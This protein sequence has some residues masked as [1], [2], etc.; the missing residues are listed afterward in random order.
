MFKIGLRKCVAALLEL[1]Q[2]VLYL[3]G[4][5]QS[6]QALKVECDSRHMSAVVIKGALGATENTDVALEA[7]QQFAKA[8]YL[9]AGTV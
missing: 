9:T 5:Q 8:C 2:I 7:L 4:I 1:V 3:F 6:R